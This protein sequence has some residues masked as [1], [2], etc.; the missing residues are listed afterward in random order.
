MSFSIA[1][2][3]WGMYIKKNI[4]F[5]NIL[6]LWPFQ[7]NQKHKTNRGNEHDDKAHFTFDLTFRMLQ[8]RSSEVTVV[9]H[10]TS[11]QK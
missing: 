5:L 9:A 11:K 3:R 4:F 1:V 10:E 8:H 6:A 2:G 7:L